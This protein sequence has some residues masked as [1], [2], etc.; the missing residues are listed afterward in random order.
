MTVLAA[1]LPRA[2][3]YLEA[4]QFPAECFADPELAGA[5]PEATPIGLPRAMSGNVAVV[6]KVTAE[7]GRA[8]AVRCFVRAF[9]DLDTRYRALVPHLRAPWAVRTEY[10]PRGIHI[11]DDWYPVVKMAWSEATPLVSWVEEHLWDTAAMSYA[12]TR[13]ASLASSLRAAG[14]AHGDLQHGNV[15]VAPGGDLRLVDYDG[16]W[17]P[18]LDGMRS[19]ELGHRNY[20]HPRRTREDFGAHLDAFPSW[21]VYTSL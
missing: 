2:A 4:L 14:V 6:F 16:M 18:E 3:D 19:N 11:G 20:A 10:Q 7:S 8:F 21:V 13:F 17:V 1:S 5:Q 9:D 15:L 12:T